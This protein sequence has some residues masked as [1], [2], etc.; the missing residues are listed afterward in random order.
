MK[1]LPSPAS[2]VWLAMSLVSRFLDHSRQSVS[3][4]CQLWTLAPSGLSSTI[5]R[6]SPSPYFAI[7]VGEN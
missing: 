2:I 5:Q 7:V 1:R 4:Q 6:L 3:A